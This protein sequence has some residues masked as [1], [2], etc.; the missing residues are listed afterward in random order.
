MRA[1]NI[2]KEDFSLKPPFYIIFISGLLIYL[3]DNESQ[4]EWTGMAYINGV[5][6]DKNSEFVYTEFE[7]H[8]PIRCFILD[9]Y[10]IDTPKDLEIARKNIYKLGF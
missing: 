3:N 2:I 1:T 4:Y 10:E 9:C 6:I 7:S 5:N 8:L